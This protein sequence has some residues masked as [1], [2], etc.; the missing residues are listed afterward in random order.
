MKVSHIFIILYLAIA[1]LY[2]LFWGL[3]YKPF[4]YNLGRG[5]VW[6]ILLFPSLGKVI[7]ALLTLVIVLILAAFA[8]KK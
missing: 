4:E 7:S 6:P 8:A 1:V 2:A 5:L 3:E